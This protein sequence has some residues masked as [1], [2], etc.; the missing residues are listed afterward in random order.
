MKEKYEEY[1]I[2]SLPLSPP[3][4]RGWDEVNTPLLT[5]PNNRVGQSIELH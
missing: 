4:S 1:R 5:S 2:K 3:W